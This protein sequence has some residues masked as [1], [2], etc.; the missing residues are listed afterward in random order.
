MTTGKKHLWTQALSLEKQLNPC[1]L[2]TVLRVLE[3]EHMLRQPVLV[4]YDPASHSLG[5]LVRIV[6]FYSE[7]YK[8]MCI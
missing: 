4:W 2:F 5:S 1:R 8:S 3:E 7:Y 6:M